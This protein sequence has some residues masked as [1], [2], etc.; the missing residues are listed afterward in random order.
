[1]QSFFPETRGSILIKF[2]DHGSQHKP[3]SHKD[4][5]MLSLQSITSDRWLSQVDSHL[6]EI[7]IDHAH[8]ERKAAGVAMSL[9]SAYVQHEELSREM[10]AIVVEELDHFRQVLDLLKRRGIRF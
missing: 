3:H 9:L 1:M 6:E 5:R 8:C 4:L 10:A 2:G 7:L